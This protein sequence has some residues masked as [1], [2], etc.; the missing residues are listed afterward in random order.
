MFVR[1]AAIVTC[2]HGD[3]L[4]TCMHGL[5]FFTFISRC[6][7]PMCV[8]VCVSLLQYFRQMLTEEG[9]RYVKD[10]LE[11]WLPLVGSGLGQRLVYSLSSD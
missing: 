6:A 4:V 10:Q 9:V 2:M 11:S 7:I 3:V 5:P 1:H 8:C